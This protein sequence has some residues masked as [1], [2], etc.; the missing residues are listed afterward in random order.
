MEIKDTLTV[1]NKNY[2]LY[3]VTQ[4]PRSVVS[5]N[6]VQ[7][8]GAQNDF[9]TL[10]PKNEYYF[11]A[12]GGGLWKT[13]D[14]GNEW[15]PVTD[16]KIS[17]S[18]RIFADGEYKDF[19]KGSYTSDYT[20]FF[21]NRVIEDILSNVDSWRI[22]AISDEKALLVFFNELLQIIDEEIDSNTKS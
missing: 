19:P 7:A 2:N 1:N 14:G 5:N 12:T 4:K 6:Y 8:V 9:S 16:G 17:S 18:N 10:N 3:Q 13:V 15:F 11:G 21:Q 22:D 20:W